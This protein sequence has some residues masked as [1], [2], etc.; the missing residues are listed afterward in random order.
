MAGGSWQ[1][2]LSGWYDYASGEDSFADAGRFGD[3]FDRLFPL[4]HKYNGLMD[5]FGRR[6]LHDINAQLITPLRGDRL[7]LL[8]WYHYFLLDNLTTPYNVNMQPFNTVAAAA[9]GELGHEL[10]ELA[11]VNLTPRNS[12]LVGYSYFAP[13]DYYRQTR[14]SVPGGGGIA[15]IADAH[16]VYWQYQMQF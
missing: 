7:S 1:P 6:N 5:L 13:G 8:L 10:D 3:G 2:T 4:A 9:D 12:M 11:T 14:A 16:F 15:T